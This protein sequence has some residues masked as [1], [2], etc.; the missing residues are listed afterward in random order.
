MNTDLE[1]ILS[2]LG[3]VC[4]GIE[5]QNPNLDIT[6]GNIYLVKNRVFS[7]AVNKLNN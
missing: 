6:M 1:E 7:P 5:Q 2:P 4:T 3:M